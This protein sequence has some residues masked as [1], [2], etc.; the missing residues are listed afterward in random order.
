VRMNSAGGWSN[1]HSQDPYSRDPRALPPPP[2]QYPQQ[3]S[4]PRPTSQGPPHHMDD[5]RHHEPDYPAPVQDPHRS[6]NVGPHAY[7]TPFS[8]NG[9]REPMV[10][11]DPSAE[12]LHVNTVRPHSTGDINADIHGRP[13]QDDPRRQSMA[14]YEN[15][16]GPPPNQ[17]Y[18]PGPP[19][20]P[21]PIQQPSTPL[22]D[23]PYEPPPTPG[24]SREAY[25]GGNQ[26]GQSSSNNQ[27]KKAP[28]AS[29]VHL[30]CVR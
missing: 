12:P 29:Q 5:R 19:Y 3:H 25:Y 22:Y 20:P 6:H 4:Y 21:P 1:G 24:G 11:R 27:R 9:P 2:Q 23:R 16:N 14:G 30:G 8:G 18:R 17:Q 13:H 15:M 10:K 7:A 28:R 26:G